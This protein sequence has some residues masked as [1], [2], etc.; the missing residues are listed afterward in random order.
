MYVTVF[1]ALLY[2]QPRTVLDNLFPFLEGG[3]CH[4][5]SQ[6]ED[7]SHMTVQRLTFSCH[8]RGLAGVELELELFIVSVCCD[9]QTKA[10]SVPLMQSLSFQADG[11]CSQIHAWGQVWWVGAWPLHPPGA[12]QQNGCLPLL[13]A[14]QNNWCLG[15]R[16]AKHYLRPQDGEAVVNTY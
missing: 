5:R 4:A 8:L 11:V 2:G 16:P 3:C 9:S 13:A 10:T 7:G 14:E 15:P 6:A 12:D 1:I